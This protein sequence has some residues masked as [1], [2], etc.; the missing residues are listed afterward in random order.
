MK[1]KKKSAAQFL[2]EGIAYLFVVLMAG[3][4]PL[5]YRNNYIDISSAKLT[6]FRTCALG[7]VIMTGLFAALGWLEE[8]QAGQKK[9]AKYRKGTGTNKEKNKKFRKPEIG[10]ETWFVI[11]FLIAVAFSTILSEH[12]LESWQGLEGRKL[13]ANVFLLCILMY[14][15]LGKYLN[16]NKWIIWIF[17]ISNGLVFLLGGLNFWEID[18]L[19]MYDNLAKTDWGAFISTTGNGNASA[20]YAC[21]ILP[22]GMVLYTLAETTGSRIAYSVFLILG[23]YESYATTSDSWMLGCGVAYLVLLWFSLTDIRR[24]KRFLELC[25]IFL[26]S[27]LI[28]KLTLVA[29]TWKNAAGIKFVTFKTLK[30]QNF[31]LNGYV[32]AAAGLLV[33]AGLLYLRNAEKRE[34]MI[35]F[36][37][38]RT[39]L[40]SIFGIIAGA[41]VLLFVAANVSSR[42]WQGAAGWLNFFKLRDE[43]GSGRGV[44]WKQTV[45]A[46][47]QLSPVKKIFGYGVNCYHQFIYQYCADAIQ[48][49]FGSHTLVDAHNEPLQFLATMGI[50]GVIGYFGLLISTA[51]AA[52]KKVSNQPLMLLGAVVLCSY[53]AQSLVNNPTVFITPNLFLFLGILK[54]IER[55]SSE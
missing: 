45:H 14:V 9:A 49:V 4:F 34:R 8:K 19:H 5:F 29:G 17:L 31:I 47:M 36:K 44:I 37:L 23:F 20:N 48:A 6:F 24:M 10:R 39:I 41:G 13:G 43:F 26:I 42:Q 30:L 40:F 55:K 18:I 50:V 52:G 53:L 22:I 3:I 16:P 33:L 11:I 21:I 7:L 25:G 27:S 1:Q 54:S 35:P 15:I 28:M 32:L 46:Y 2:L 38:L 12:P 51:A